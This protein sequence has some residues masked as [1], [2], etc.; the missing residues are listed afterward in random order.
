M[1]CARQLQARAH[2]L[3]A[4]GIVVHLY[5]LAMRCVSKKAMRGC[6]NT[7]EFFRAFARN[8]CDRHARIDVSSASID[9]S[10]T[11]FSLASQC[12][13]RASE[14]Q[15]RACMCRKSRT[16]HRRCDRRVVDVCES[17]DRVDA[18]GAEVDA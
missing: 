5:A 3:R 7:H 18:F 8:R 4:R 6:D 1:L 12:A 9:T 14:D 11:R 16:A 13:M 17:V 15:R 2:R 10:M